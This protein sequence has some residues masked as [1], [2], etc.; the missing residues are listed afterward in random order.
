MD[1]LVMALDRHYKYWHLV[2]GMKHHYS[3]AGTLM[4]I[5]I[6]FYFKHVWII[7]HIK[8]EYSA[9]VCIY[10]LNICPACMHALNIYKAAIELLMCF[11]TKIVA[12]KGMS[13]YWMEQH[14]L[15]DRFSFITMA[16]GYQFMV[17]HMTSGGQMRQ[18]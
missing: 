8:L 5:T 4:P 1:I 13:D 2:L 15:K 16:I 10:Y 12:K 17:I 7:T 9:K 14:V 6:F 11:L 3:D 18:M